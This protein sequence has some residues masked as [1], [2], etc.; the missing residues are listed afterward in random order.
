MYEWLK[1]RYKKEGESSSDSEADVKLWTHD[2]WL[3]EI[4]ATI[5]PDRLFMYGE[6]IAD[7]EVLTEAEKL[8]LLDRIYDAIGKSYIPGE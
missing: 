3:D 1:R 7:S 5:D 2:E 8:K 4:S 6:I